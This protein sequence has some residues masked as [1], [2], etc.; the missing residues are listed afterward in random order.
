MLRTFKEDKQIQLKQ[1]VAK[2]QAWYHLAKMHFLGGSRVC[3]Q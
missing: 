1:V 3:K 2:E